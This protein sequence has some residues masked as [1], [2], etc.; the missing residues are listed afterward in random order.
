MSSSLWSH[1]LKYTRLLCP[2]DFSDKNTGMDCL[3]LLQRIF[4][5]QGWS[6]RL[7]LCKQILYHCATWMDIFVMYEDHWIEHKLTPHRQIY[8]SQNLFCK[9]SDKLNSY[10]QWYYFLFCYKP[11]RTFF[12]NFSLSLFIIYIAT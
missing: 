9:L 5:T 2:W 11:Y 12:I 7:L 8:S 6:L 10:I 4:P 3:F 1:W